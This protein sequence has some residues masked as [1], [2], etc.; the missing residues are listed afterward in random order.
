MFA[1]VTNKA[2]RRGSFRS[3]QSL[4]KAIHEYLDARPNKPFDWTAT[5]DDILANIERF[6][7]RT[8][9]PRL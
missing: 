6:C 5:A 8:S 2:I 1:E 9:R 7:L 3:V 4:E